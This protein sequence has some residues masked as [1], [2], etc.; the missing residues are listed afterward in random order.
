MEPVAS[1]RT[2][3]PLKRPATG[4]LVTLAG[5]LQQLAPP[6][7]LPPVISGHNNY[8]LW[9]P[10]TCS[11]KVLILVGYTPS[12]L[13]RVHILYAHTTRAVVDR[14]RYCVDYERTLPIYVLS[15]ATRPVF[16]RRWASLKHYD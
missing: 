4:L 9:G 15:G 13:R 3:P 7:R 12:D 14:C 10:G 11:G 5:A 8:S 6:D 2:A 16:P 1:H